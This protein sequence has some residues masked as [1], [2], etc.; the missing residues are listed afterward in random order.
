MSIRK[1]VLTPALSLLAAAAAAVVFSGGTAPAH[2]LEPTFVT[3]VNVSGTVS[4]SPE[5]VSFG[6]PARV[7]SRLAPDPD[8]NSPHLILMIDM[9]EVEG[10]GAS[11]RKKY[12]VPPPEIVQRRLAAN[13]TVEVLFPYLET[14][15]NLETART[16]VVSFALTFDVNTGA[17]T[18]ASG[19]VSTPNF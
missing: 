7:S 8:F 10:I 9:S 18:Q 14:G 1:T 11:S 2:A 4:D 6:G 13:H 19:S 5:S 3:V 12:V 16:A 15:K 17:I